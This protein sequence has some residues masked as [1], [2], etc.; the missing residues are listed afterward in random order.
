MRRQN[1]RFQSVAQKPDKS[2]S[3]VKT[4]GP[5]MVGHRE[6]MLWEKVKVLFN[7]NAFWIFSSLGSF[8]SIGIFFM[9]QKAGSEL[10]L[11]DDSKYEMKIDLEEG[12]FPGQE[13]KGKSK[14]RRKMSSE[15][16]RK[17]PKALIGS[18]L[19]MLTRVKRDH[20]FL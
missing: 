8:A 18:A 11:D 12:F 9:K 3:L 4:S 1:F 17:C 15:S 16:K 5:S 13:T 2:R 20:I 14:I 19:H 6:N 7:K 10:L